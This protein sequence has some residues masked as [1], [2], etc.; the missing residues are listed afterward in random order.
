MD[1]ALDIRVVSGADAQRLRALRLAALET[2][3]GAFKSTYEGDAARPQEWWERWAAESEEGSAQRTFAVAG[4][5]GRWLGLALVRIEP[6]RS[7]AAVIHS[8][9]VSPEARGRGAARALCDACAGWA[10]ERGCRVVTLNAVAGNER[11]LR[12]YRSAG[13]VVRGAE[14]AVAADGR[15]VEEVVLSRDLDPDA[16][17]EGVLAFVSGALPPAPARVLEVG[18]GSGEL[19]EALRR[20]GYDVVAIDPASGSPAVRPVALHELDEPDAS[21]DAAVAVVSLHHVE[22]LAESSRR[23]AAVL[24]P[25]GPLVVDE[26]DVERFDERAAAWWLARR[27]VA[28]DHEPGDPP[29]IVAHLREHLHSLRDV[30]G[31]LAEWFEL[32]EPVRGPYLYRW[33]LPPGMRGAEE[34]LIA[35]GRLP[36]TGARLVGARGP[37]E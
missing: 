5:D 36:A 1:G 16:G 15:A 32:G 27:T 3:P 26:F 6:E 25:G 17:S 11:A 20:R 13:F 8:M 24:K 10:A 35:S 23:L 18:A 28:H 33:N 9:W 31:A 19:A 7:G 12:S 30:R 4:D 29:A 2:D 21:F 22:P 37:L 14:T 34:E